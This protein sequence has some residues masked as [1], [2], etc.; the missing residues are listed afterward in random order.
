VTK[1]GDATVVRF[2]PA[3]WAAWTCELYRPARYD[4]ENI[5]DGLDGVTPWWWHVDTSDR[6]ARGRT[7]WPTLECEQRRGHPTPTDLCNV[8]GRCVGTCNDD[9]ARGVETT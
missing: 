7:D 3:W 6:R 1:G 4:D 8:H 2:S 9:A 5:P